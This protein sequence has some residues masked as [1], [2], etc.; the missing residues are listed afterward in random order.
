MPAAYLGVGL[1]RI[2]NSRLRRSRGASL[3]LWREIVRLAIS[4]PRHADALVNSHL[5]AIAF[6]RGFG[7][8]RAE[9]TFAASKWLIAGISGHVCHAVRMA[10]GTRFVST[11]SNISSSS[12]TMRA[13]MVATHFRLYRPVSRE[14]DH[15]A[16]LLGA[17]GLRKKALKLLH[18]IGH[19]LIAVLRLVSESG[20]YR[21]SPMAARRRD[22]VDDGTAASRTGLD[23]AIT[24]SLG[25]IKLNA[26]VDLPDPPWR[27][28]REMTLR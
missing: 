13:C 20:S 15:L 19:W 7:G 26:S 27:S 10:R 3:S 24:V 2:R 22:L 12:V 6:A 9:R 17:G 14:A 28:T 18:V 4:K 25:P 11:N 1:W 5:W 16:Y 21:R 23:L 8:Q